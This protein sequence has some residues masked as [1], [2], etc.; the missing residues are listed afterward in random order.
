MS[1]DLLEYEKD[2]LC[3]LHLSSEK[4]D[5]IASNWEG[6][7]IGRYQPLAKICFVSHKNVYVT[8]F[9]IKDALVVRSIKVVLKNR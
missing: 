3:S 9:I 2:A 4:A 6:S 1:K 5:L 7:V 8:K